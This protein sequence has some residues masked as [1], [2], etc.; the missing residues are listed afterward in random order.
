MFLLSDMINQ[1]RI[2]RFMDRS[3]RKALL[4]ESHDDCLEVVNNDPLLFQLCIYFF[5]CSRLIYT[6]GL[7]FNHRLKIEVCRGFIRSWMEGIRLYSEVNWPITTKMST[8]FVNIIF[9]NI[10][11]ISVKFFFFSLLN[12]QLGTNILLLWFLILGMVSLIKC[13]L[14]FPAGEKTL[15]HHH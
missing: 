9:T 2:H 4:N 12:F 14:V 8:Q 10:G 5:F 6:Y 15:Q 7:S 11:R 13:L 1:G 3:K